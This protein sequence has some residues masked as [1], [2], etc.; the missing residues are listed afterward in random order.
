M[1]VSLFLGGKFQVSSCFLGS[2][3]K[4]CRRGQRDPLEQQLRHAVNAAFTAQRP[5]LPGKHPL[6]DCATL[7]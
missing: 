5:L 7:N 3:E 6:Q 2:S 1:N 4:C